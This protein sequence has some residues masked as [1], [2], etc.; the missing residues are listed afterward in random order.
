MKE[1][2]GY[3]ELEQSNGFGE[4]YPSMIALNSARNALLYLVRAKGIK[5]LFIPYYLCD[6]ISSVCERE[7][8]P[9]ECYHI[10]S[11]LLPDFDKNLGDDEYLYIVNY[12]GLLSDDEILSFKLEVSS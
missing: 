10:S 4:Y 5:K 12:Y 2:G 8:I 3:F 9:Y 6:S 11:N 7:S 1:I